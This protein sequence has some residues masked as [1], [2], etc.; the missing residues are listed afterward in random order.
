MTALRLAALLGLASI[1][2]GAPLTWSEEQDWRSRIRIALFV[3]GAPPALAVETHGTFEPEPGVL[4]ERITYASQF[5]LRIPVILYRPRSMRAKAPGLIV[6]N[7]HGG[8]KYAWYAMYAGIL[9]ARA[10]AVVLTYDPAGEGERNADRKSGTRSHDKVE[11]PPELAQRLG[12]L[13]MTDVMQAVSY[14]SQ[15]PEVDKRRL[16]AFGYS[17]GSFVL[18]LTCA[19]ETR[20]KACVLVGGGNLDGPGGYWDSSKQMCQGIPYKSLEFLQDRPAAIYALHAARGPTLVYNGLEDTTV[21]IPRFGEPYFRELQ[22]RVARLR[23]KREGVF[24]TG[25]VPGAGHRPYFVTKP[26]A[27]WLEQHLDFPNWTAEQIETMP[28]THISEW[29]R[30]NRVEMDPLYSSEHREGGVRALGTGVPGLT[31]EDLS[32]FNPSEWETRKESFIHPAWL[33]K[34]KARIAQ[35]ANPLE[36]LRLPHPRLILDGAGFE[37]IRSLVRSDPFARRIYDAVK[38]QAG[39]IVA[40]PPARYEVRNGRMLALSRRTVDR[41]YT[42]GLMYRLDRDKRYL[43]RAAVELRAVSAFPSWQDNFLDKAEMIHAVAIGYDWFYDGLAQADREAI[44]AALLDK[45]LRHAA[46][47]HEEQRWWAVNRFNWNPVCNGGVTLGALAIA[48]EEPELART[49]LR[50]MLRS[51]PLA[52]S[53]YA[54]DG[55]WAEGPEYWHYATRYAVHLLSGLRSALGHD[56]GLS[57][58][59]GFEQTGLFR[60][61]AIGPTGKLYNFSDSDE[62][63]ESAPEMFWLARRFQRPLYANRQREHIERARSFSALDLIW[64]PPGDLR[65][66]PEQPPL[67]RCFRDV[68]VATMRTSWDDPDAIW[69]GVKG[70]Q[71]RGGRGHAQLDLGS[72]VMDAAGTRWALDLGRNDYSVPGYFGKLRFTYYRT[73][74]ESHN[75]V[76]IDGANQDAVAEAPIFAHRFAP[77]LSYVQID[78]AQAYREKVRRFERGVALY[79]GRHVIVQDEIQ[80]RV[81]VQALWGLVTDAEVALQGR[82][83]ALIKGERVVTARIV[84]PGNAAFGIVSTQAPSGQTPNGNTRKL[85]VRLPGKTDDLRLVVALT[86]HRRGTALP[87]LDW[88]DRPL[89]AWQ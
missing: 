77:A 64:L 60:I 12:G 70:G 76:L 85:V 28:E 61:H 9:Y 54:P 20:L 17:M 19:V 42:L 39:K 72:F 79:R 34:A 89:G 11:P 66:G 27:L 82:E 7:G 53:S 14:L 86:P 45:G 69:V 74:T 49:L 37:R 18:S 63:P 25:F 62:E 26:V 35:E 50:Y 3:G 56:F 2:P 67:S 78:L 22:E 46:P 4:A 84:T 51:F 59:N 55:G 47:I 15:R 43:D 30:R 52:L 38:E 1:A 33:K 81:P 87:A 83:A 40:E 13:M 58:S 48:G 16:A 88:K 31:R 21:S 41:M 57:D 65:A 68:E 29:A 6:V 32:V 36:G 80:S 5:G 8:D 75:T 24:D 71:N 73:Q 44:R 10:G 23:G